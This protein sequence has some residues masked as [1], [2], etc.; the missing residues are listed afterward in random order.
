MTDGMVITALDAQK[1]TLANGQRNKTQT[2]SAHAT[3]LKTST[4]MKLK[5]RLL[6]ESQRHSMFMLACV[7]ATIISVSCLLLN[8]LSENG[9]FSAVFAMFSLL[10]ASAALHHGRES[11]RHLGLYF[12]EIKFQRDEI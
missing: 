10:L 9:F 1:T 7:F 12:N 5:Q 3:N 2:T 6:N 11:W 8:I 4:D